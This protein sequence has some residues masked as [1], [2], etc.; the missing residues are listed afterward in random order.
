MEMDERISRG[1]QRSTV[2]AAQFTLLP[3]LCAPKSYIYLDTKLATSIAI[4]FTR[5]RAPSSHRSPL[6]QPVQPSLLTVVV[7]V[8]FILDT[9]IQHPHSKTH[10]VK[11]ESTHQE[12][13]MTRRIARSHSLLWLQTSLARNFAR[14]LP[15]SLL[16][17]RLL[18]LLF[19]LLSVLHALHRISNITAQ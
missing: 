9:P 19:A 11:S 17:F 4:S 10:T 7:Y 13:P 14:A 8:P 1:I 6:F 18:C 12:P 5:H 15:N 2:N 3:P 16:S